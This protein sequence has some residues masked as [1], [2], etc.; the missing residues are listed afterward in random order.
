MSVSVSMSDKKPTPSRPTLDHLIPEHIS[1]LLDDR[2]L[3]WFEDAPRYDGLLAELIGAY[4]PK[5][6]LEFILIKD[7]CDAQWEI[8]RLRQ[9]RQA[10]VEAEFSG[11]AWQLMKEDFP[12]VADQDFHSARNTLRVM[13]RRAIQGDAKMRK[14]LDRYSAKVGVTTRMIHYEALKIGMKSISAIEDNLAKAERRRDQM[15]RMIEDRR[16]NLAA[17]RRSLVD[18]AGAAPAIE[19]TAPASEEAA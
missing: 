10:A 15:I 5:G 19:A 3:L 7:V 2:P 6:A 11:A 1:N 18:R 17:M 9:L 13:S 14:D 8:M 4:D 16:R 12:S